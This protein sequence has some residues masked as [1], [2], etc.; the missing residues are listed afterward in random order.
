MVQPAVL[1]A[2][3]VARLG[4]RTSSKKVWQKGDLPLISGMGEMR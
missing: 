3:Q 2:D 1:L 4:T